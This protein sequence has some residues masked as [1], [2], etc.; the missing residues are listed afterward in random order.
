MDDNLSHQELKSAV[1][2]KNATMVFFPGAGSQVLSRS[3]SSPVDA[4]FT[5]IPRS[6]CG[7][8]DVHGGVLIVSVPL[9]EGSFGLLGIGGGARATE[10]K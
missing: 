10:Q 2:V 6:A 4:R 5:A 8:G 1:W 9:M 3:I 7:D